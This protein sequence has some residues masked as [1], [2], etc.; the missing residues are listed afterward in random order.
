MFIFNSTNSKS[1]N[2]IMAN[3]QQILAFP[4][5]NYDHGKYVID[6]PLDFIISQT[7]KCL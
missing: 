4:P 3:F 6:T 7:I 1:C 2:I 5:M